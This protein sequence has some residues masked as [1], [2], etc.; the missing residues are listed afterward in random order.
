MTASSAP[1]TAG[2]SSPSGRLVSL[3][4]FRGFTIAVMVIVNNPGNW[5]TI[6]SPLLHA[7][8]HGWTPTDL[9]FPFFLFIVGVSITLSR[10]SASAAAIAQRAAVIF[11]I[12]L[13]LNAYP[14]FELATLRIPGVLQRIAV[15]YLVAALLFNAT[16]RSP[17]QPVVVAALAAALRWLLAGNGAGAGA[18]RHCRRSFAGGQRRAWID[19]ALMDGHLWK[20]RWDPEGL[21]STVPAVATALLWHPRRTVAG[22]SPRCRG[23]GPRPAARRRRRHRARLRMERGVPDQQEPVDEA[24]TCC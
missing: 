10:K 19:R 11:A 15:C 13:F 2:S 4:V 18:R 7:P 23:K 16:R 5:D 12:G 21:L 3:D 1:A 24:G 8:W 17:R 20:P 22:I 9:V 14:E 6:Y